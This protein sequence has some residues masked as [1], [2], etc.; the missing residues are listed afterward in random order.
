MIGLAVGLAF[1]LAAIPAGR[2]L[3]TLLMVVPMVGWFVLLTIGIDAGLTSGRTTRLG[4][5]LLGIL[6][7]LTIGQVFD[8]RDHPRRPRR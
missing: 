6:L 2:R 4:L 1:S 7:G 5:G 3:A 8:R